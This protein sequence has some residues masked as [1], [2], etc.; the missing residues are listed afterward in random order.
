MDIS[1]LDT[2]NRV[3]RDF[4]SQVEKLQ[5]QL[6]KETRFQK[7]RIEKHGEAQVFIIHIRSNSE[8][9][10]AKK[11]LVISEQSK[12]IQ[13]LES[14]LSKANAIIKAHQVLFVYLSYL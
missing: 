13:E 12:K 9:L 7:E 11:D 8:Q 2:D 6:E 3:I 10:L 1:K 5:A 4:E 14:Q